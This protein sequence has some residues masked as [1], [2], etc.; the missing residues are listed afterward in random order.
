[1]SEFD[2][3]AYLARKTAKAS[4]RASFDPDAYL[5]KKQA[6]I[7][8]PS[9]AEALLRG[10]GQGVTMNLG[11][12]M[13]GGVRAVGDSLPTWLGGDDRK[14]GFADSYRRN[15]DQVRANNERARKAHE[16][17]YTAGEVGGGAATM[18]VPGLGI[19]KGAKLATA[20]GKMALGGGIAGFGASDA[21]VTNGEL[22]GAAIDTATG[23]GVGAVAGAGG[24]LLE[25]GLGAAAKY[26]AKK[27]D[28]LRQL[29]KGV[30]K[31]EA[32][33]ITRGTVSEAGRASTAAYKNV[34]N[35]IDAGLEGTITDPAEKAAFNE[36][37]QELGESGLKGLLG[38]RN[39]KKAAMEAMKK[40]QA[41]EAQVAEE[42]AARKLSGAEFG[43]KAKERLVRYGLPAVGSAALAG[44]TGYDSPGQLIA[45]AGGGG[46]AGAGLRPMMHSMLRL[47][48]DPA[49]RNAL[50]RLLEH[51][52]SAGAASSPVTSRAIA[53]GARQSAPSAA[54]AFAK[55]LGQGDEE[56]ALAGR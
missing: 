30:G 20:A 19:A 4:G 22:G 49:S 55:L 32:A 8:A 23:A 47:A 15:R 16:N 51:G 35:I 44:A 24:H 45:A 39:A 46:L 50:W 14:G 52:G 38:D 11:D 48:K 10:L 13:W 34:R 29:I 25:K 36:L 3:D 27:G 9:E 26:G 17:Y 43:R 53:S 18:L 5:A 42:I 7:D 2:P 12:E 37:K 33:A 28:A 21:D 31:E 56:D 41:E 6:E 40:A 1:M 54:H